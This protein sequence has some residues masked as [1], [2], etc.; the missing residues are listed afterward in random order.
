[1]KQKD[2]LTKLQAHP[3]TSESMKMHYYRG[4]IYFALVELESMKAMSGKA[5]DED[6]ME[7]YSEIS[8]ESF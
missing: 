3:E 6:M 4:M 1:M 7:K 8:K 5:P 2:S